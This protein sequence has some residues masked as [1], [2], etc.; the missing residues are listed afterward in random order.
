M[1]EY[2]ESQINSNETER[3]SAEQERIN[4][5]AQRQTKETEREAR[6]ATRQSNESTRISKEAERLAEEVNRQEAEASRVAAENN[7]G[8]RL[9]ELENEV[10][11]L[12]TE[13]R[14]T[15]AE[16]QN[17]VSEIQNDM[18]YAKMLSS[19]VTDAYK[20]TVDDDEMMPSLVT[21]NDI[22][23]SSEIKINNLNE[24]RIVNTK[25]K[26]ICTVNTNSKNYFKD[27]I[28][29]GSYHGAEYTREGND[30]TVFRLE[31]YPDNPTAY[32][33]ISLD[34]PNLTEGK[35]YCLFCDEVI[36][37][38]GASAIELHSGG[39]QYDTG[40]TLNSRDIEFSSFNKIFTYSA[41]RFDFRLHCTVGSQT[42]N[43]TFK[44]MQI[45]EIKEITV[46]DIQLKSLPNG[47][48]DEIK[49]GMLIKRT[50][51]VNLEDLTWVVSSTNDGANDYKVYYTHDVTDIKWT[52]DRG[53]NP[54][55]ILCNMLPC[56]SNAGTAGANDPI[57][58]YQ[59]PGISSH[60]ERS[61]LRIKVKASDAP[62]LNSLY[63]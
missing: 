18:T 32:A 60:A 58:Q 36:I 12:G 49:D 62:D 43:V 21:L 53:V 47:L 40:Q 48:K 14:G 52:T 10:N 25:I 17:D 24:R 34:I 59:T 41:N 31:I 1:A 13:L 22:I 57:A 56:T 35:K 55:T 45:Y 37:N 23:G 15:D 2:N 8:I 4:N 19:T 33:F 50:N 46:P 39:R 26:S 42:G 27:M 38:D 28:W 6:E 7:R 63:T 51:Q 30:I 9:T 3:I 44:N 54:N 5:E 20:F 11:A 16:I 29:L 61:E